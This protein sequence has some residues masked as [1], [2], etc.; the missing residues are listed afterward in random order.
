MNNPQIRT[1]CEKDKETI[2]AFFGKV[3]FE[4]NR[5]LNLHGKDTDLLDIERSYCTQGEFWILSCGKNIVGTIALRKLRDFY[6]IRR[7]F[8]LQKYKHFGYGRLMLF[9][10]IKYAFMNGIPKLKIATMYSGLEINHLLSKYHFYPIENYNHSSADL[11]WQ[12]D[13]DSK[14][15]YTLF[16]SR[17]DH[18]LKE[19]LILNP[20][21]NFPYYEDFNTDNFEDIYVSERYKSIEDIVIFGKRNEL[22]DLY[23]ITKQIWKTH[24]NAYDVDLKTMS[25]LNAHLIFFL[26]VANPGDSVLLL[27]EIA[28]GHYSTENMLRK[29][30]MNVFLFPVDFNSQCIDIEKSTKLIH[31][32]SP[33][34]IFIDRSEGINYEDF[35][36]LAEFSDSIKV[37]DASQYLSQILTG[38][39]PN[40]FLQGF[41]YLLSSLHKNYP[42]PQKSII[43]AKNKTNLWSK[44]LVESKTFI[45][46][47]HPQ[48]IFKSVVPLL[49]KKFLD[50]YSTDSI[51]LSNDLYYKLLQLHIPVIERDKRFLPTPH[52][53]IRPATQRK[54]YELFLK[55][56]EAGICTNYRKLP[57][58]LGFGLRLG[59]NGAIRQG[60]KSTHISLLAKYIA[61]IYNDTIYNLKLYKKI[62]KFVQSIIAK[63]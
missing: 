28:G 31:E 59:L 57:Y 46:N 60:L 13:L 20:T 10:V 17:A 25:G 44:F 14:T 15:V 45:S 48:N 37:F 19:S 18:I 22:I 3:F 5:T 8:I 16:F 2:L 30:G 62:R 12:L 34:F 24:L 29:I 43:A 7:F 47:T 21:E 49:N 40:P 63:S 42:G 23:D 38:Y 11:F 32:I 56:E 39:Y 33:K 1:Y 52:I 36:W 9:T 35:S 27:P 50:E 4:N 26:C 51:S 53:W 54:A 58:N 61:E 6:E 41:D 55:L